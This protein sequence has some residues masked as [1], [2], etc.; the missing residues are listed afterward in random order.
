MTKDCVPPASNTRKTMK[1]SE[2]IAKVTLQPVPKARNLG[3]IGWADGYLLVRFKTSTLWV[4]GPNIPEVKRDQI[5]ANRYPDSLF[6]KAIKNKYQC[7]KV[8]HA[9]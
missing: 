6:T 7:F 8:E 5:L 1:T 2:L 3:W 4:Y 9:A